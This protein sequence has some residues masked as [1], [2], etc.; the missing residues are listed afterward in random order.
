MLLL[1][2]GIGRGQGGSPSQYQG[3]GQSGYTGM[4]APLQQAATAQLMYPPYGYARMIL[5]ENLMGLFSLFKHKGVKK[6]IIFA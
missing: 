2:D 6:F 5:K 3:G 1:F 4:A